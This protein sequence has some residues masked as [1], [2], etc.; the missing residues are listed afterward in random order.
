MQGRRQQ[1]QENGR[2]RMQRL[3]QFAAPVLPSEERLRPPLCWLLFW[4]HLLL[5]ML[6]LLSLLLVLVLLLM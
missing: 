4:Q 5:L 2:V 1:A 6:L 3:W